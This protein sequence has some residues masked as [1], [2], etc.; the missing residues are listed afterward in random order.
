MRSPSAESGVPHHLLSFSHFLPRIELCPEKR[1][2]RYPDLMKA[3]IFFEPLEI[4]EN[5]D[6]FQN[7]QFWKIEGVEKGLQTSSD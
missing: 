4:L 1:F 2:L 7:L 5:F 6:H 3:F